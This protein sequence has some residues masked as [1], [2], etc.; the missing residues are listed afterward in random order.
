LQNLDKNKN[1]KLQSAL[2]RVNSS[3]K[4]M[5]DK[6]NEV[7]LR[8]VRDHGNPT[9]TVIMKACYLIDLTAVRRLGHQITD[10]KYIRYN[11]G[12]FTQEVYKYLTKL[13]QDG[14]VKPEIAYFGGNEVTTYKSEIPA[15]TAQVALTAEEKNVLDEVL[16]S[17][18]GLGAAILT[19]ITY[20]TAPMVRL[21][22]TL[23][24]NEAL[25]ETLDL[26]A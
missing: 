1:K 15:D 6:I 3:N 7:L 21:G 22:A 26:S 12:P 11:Y 23:G 14:S 20:K 8:I 17:I 4:T 19:D 2:W 5:S 13:I 9:I 25:G 18:N 10:L 24:G 16:S